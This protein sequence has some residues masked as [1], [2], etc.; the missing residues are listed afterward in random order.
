M[1]IK[2]TFVPGLEKYYSELERVYNLQKEADTILFVTARRMSKEILMCIPTHEELIHGLLNL[3]VTSTPGIDLIVEW[4][5]EKR[6]VL[7]T[8]LLMGIKQSQD[9]V[10]KKGYQPRSLRYQQYLLLILGLPILKKNA[11]IK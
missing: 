1:D 2:L 9:P 10:S 5:D 6:T 4:G 3:P 8:I 11:L 7:D